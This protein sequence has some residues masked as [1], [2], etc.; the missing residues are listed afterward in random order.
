MNNRRRLLV[1]LAALTF[2]AAGAGAAQGEWTPV[3]SEEFGDDAH[4]LYVM[5]G[6]I[7]FGDQPDTPFVASL[8]QGGLVLENAVDPSV[9]RYYF[10]E[11]EHAG[12]W[13]D[14]AGR[15]IAASV[16]LGGQYGEAAGAGLIYGAEPGGESFYSFVLTGGQSYGIFVLDQQGY[17]SLITGDSQH[18]APN[19]ANELIVLPDGSRLHL[20][21][22]GELVDTIDTATQPSGPSG[23][24]IGLV[25]AG[26][27]R[28][29]FDDFQVHVR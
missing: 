24:G 15:P 19:S 9:I 14:A 22:N 27:G 25:V 5:A 8:A 20:V 26:T 29:V 17:R 13:Q 23:D 7:A 3:F 1:A 11:P 12:P 6:V 18:I 21:V 16:T 2:G 28:W 10:V 4:P